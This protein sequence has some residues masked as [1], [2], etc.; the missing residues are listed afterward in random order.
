MTLDRCDNCGKELPTGYGAMADGFTIERRPGIQVTAL[1]D[2]GPGPW[3]A[4]SWLCVA[5][6]ASSRVDAGQ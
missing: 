1:S 4:C 2:L 6:Y 3:H 5:V